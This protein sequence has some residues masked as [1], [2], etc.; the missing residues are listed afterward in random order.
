MAYNNRGVVRFILGDSDGAMNDYD[1]A[2]ALD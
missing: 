2:I 1:R